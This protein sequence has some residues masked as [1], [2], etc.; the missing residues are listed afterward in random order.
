M[1]LISS[2]AATT[3]VAELRRPCANPWWATLPVMRNSLAAG[4]GA[5]H[6]AGRPPGRNHCH[7]LH[8]WIGRSL[9]S[10]SFYSRRGAPNFG[11]P[12][13]RAGHTLSVSVNTPPPLPRGE[14]G[15][16]LRLSP[17]LHN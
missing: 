13:R 7:D 5:V 2:I 4:P 15:E 8:P 3:A 1:K 12:V 17:Q 10:P 9:P 16:P 6:R 14:G 11:A